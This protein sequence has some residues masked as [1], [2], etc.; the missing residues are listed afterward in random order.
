MLA[1]L[2]HDRH[3]ASSPSR[4]SRPAASCRGGSESRRGLFGAGRRS[5]RGSECRKSLHTPGSKRGAARGRGRE[6]IFEQINNT[7]STILYLHHDQQGSTR[8]L[9]GST[10]KTEATFTYDAY[11]NQT[12]HTGTATTPMGYDG[13]Y[14]NADTGLIYLRAREYDPA[15]GQFLSVDPQVMET[16]APYAYAEDNPI[17]LG[18]PTGLIPWSPKIKEAQ[19]KCGSWKAWHSKKSPFYGNRNIYHAC[20]DLLSLPSQVYGTGGQGGG[21]IT[22]GTKAS[23]LCGL[24]GAPVALITRGVSGGPETAI[25]VSTF[26]VGY[27]T[28]E[29]IVDPLL[30]DVAP[31]VFPE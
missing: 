3:T 24:S 17:T 25:A 6:N 1:T 12:G 15:T 9:T 14:T 5:R 21:S 16:R 31:S 7:T 27:A 2:A 13:Q 22:T 11:G 20:L 28:G 29:L 23:V 26:C 18:D 8:L 30:H 19:A 10:G 4:R